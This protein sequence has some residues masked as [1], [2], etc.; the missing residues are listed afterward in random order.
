MSIIFLYKKK[1]ILF[2]SIFLFTINFISKNSFAQ[3]NNEII[4]ESYGYWEKI[5]NKDKANCVGAQFVL[6]SSGKKIGRIVVTK[7]K[8]NEKNIASIVNI[9]FPFET[10]TINLRSG[11]SITVD[12]LEPLKE[13][14]FYCDK[15]GCNAR[16]QFSDIGNE[17][18]INGSNLT[19][20]FLD[21]GKNNTIQ[22][23]DVSLLNY[24]KMFKSLDY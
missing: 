15:K 13:K 19:I 7:A 9:F 1:I 22:V 14:F 10:S 18:L 11:L 3:N 5:C 4:A 6:D 17:A 16:I 24:K 20:K 2:L 8:K 23:L 12:Q 21:I